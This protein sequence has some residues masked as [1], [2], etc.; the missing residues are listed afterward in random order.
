MATR[1]GHHREKGQDLVEYALVLPV[2]LLLIAAIMWFAMLV[3]SK[4]TIAN[5]AREGARTGVVYY[6]T[7]DERIAAMTAAVLD[8]ALALGLTTDN[9][10]ITFPEERMLRVEVTYD[11]QLLSGLSQALGINNTVT[12][13]TTVTMRME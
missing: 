8:R 10:T 13:H 1:K 6:E 11:Y 4:F 3:F 5:A 9:L 7:E 12:L 2:L